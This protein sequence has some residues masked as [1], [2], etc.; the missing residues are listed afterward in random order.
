MKGTVHKL[1]SPDKSILVELDKN[2][3]YPNDPGMGTPV[4]I[5]LRG[6]ASGSWNCV[7]SEGEVE[8]HPLTRSQS[9]WLESIAPTVWAWMQTHGVSAI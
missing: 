4:M 9:A 6:G 7:I 8:G 1:Q 5:Y 3:I 2:E